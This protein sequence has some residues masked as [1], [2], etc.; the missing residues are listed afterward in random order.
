MGYIP[1]F[2]HGED[3]TDI[4]E[5]KRN[6]PFV[7]HKATQGKLVDSRMQS[8]VK[9]FEKNKIPY[10]LYVF[11]NNGD[12][13]EQVKYMVAQTE[14][15]TGDYFVGYVL[16]IERDNNPGDCL[17]ALKWLLSSGKKVMVY[18]M[19]SQFERYSGLVRA[20]AGHSMAAVWEARYGANNGKYSAKYPPHNGVALHQFTDRGK[21][22]GLSGEIDLNRITGLKPESWFTTPAK[23]ETKKPSE[24]KTTEKKVSPK[25]PYGGKFPAIPNRGYFQRGD[26]FTVPS[27]NIKRIQ[28][29][30]NW[31][32]CSDIAIDG[33][34][35]EKTEAAVKKFQ[36]KAG[37]K[38]DGKYG[39][40]TL[41]AAKK[42]KK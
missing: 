10:W 22:P 15:I 3:I 17:E 14:K 20:C 4:K 1:D 6:C 28:K 5:I 12:E 25:K 36:K 26:G 13:L 11:L 8:R 24:K 33:K 32:I 16:D 38:Q 18:F 23:K 30:M 7:I 37:I 39:R 34:Y 42:F 19:Y 41:A 9:A 29:F 27:E 31:A 40:K 2:Y 35:G 21:C